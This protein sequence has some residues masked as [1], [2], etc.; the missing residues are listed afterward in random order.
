MK[1][2]EWLREHYPA[3]G[4]ACLEEFNKHFGVN[5]T[6]HMIQHRVQKHKIRCNFDGKFHKK[7][8]PYNVLEIGTIKNFAGINYIKVAMPNE[9]EALARYNYKKAY[10]VNLNRNDIILHLD[11]N[12]TNDSHENLIKIDR[13]I[14]ARLNKN[15]FITSNAELTKLGVNL[16]TLQEQLKEKTNGI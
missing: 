1:E 10:G 13:K 15:G 5:Y 11:G 4:T 2:I 14:L 9:W 6:V 8:V 16:L 12:V 7:Q 3:Q